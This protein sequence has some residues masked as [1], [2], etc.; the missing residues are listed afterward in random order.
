MCPVCRIDQD[1]VESNTMRGGGVLLA[2]RTELGAVRINFI[3]LDLP[4]IDVV[5]VKLNQ[6]NQI[7]YNNN[8]L[9]KFPEYR[10]VV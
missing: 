5:I 8:R 7:L 2:I 6:Q 1:F 4:I 10:K 3:C 9:L